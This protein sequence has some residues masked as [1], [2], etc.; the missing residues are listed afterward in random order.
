L[1]RLERRSYSL[2]DPDL[3]AAMSESGPLAALSRAEAAAID[4]LQAAGLPTHVGPFLRTG[5]GAWVE[6]PPNWRELGRTE[7]IAAVPLAWRDGRAVDVCSIT[8]LVAGR[9]LR[10]E[11]YAAKVVWGA[12]QVRAALSCGDAMSAFDWGWRTAE[13]AGHLE[14][15]VLGWTRAA[16]VGAKVRARSP[17]QSEVHAA[18]IAEDRRLAADGVG[19][20]R[21]RAQKVADGANAKME[22]V[23][24]ALQRRKNQ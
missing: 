18:W 1:K 6:L 11:W 2:D 7:R 10:P 23:R 24:K 12:S 8:E 13:V 17:N 3:A 14:L 5:E 20:G 16:E 15:E 9:E 21:E 4:V 22:T 19:S